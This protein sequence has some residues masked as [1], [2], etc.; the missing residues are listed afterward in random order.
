MG[1]DP[2]QQHLAPPKDTKMSP[3]LPKPEGT[4][5]LQDDGAKGEGKESGGEV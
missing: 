5:E 2:K 3:S 4:E 1:P